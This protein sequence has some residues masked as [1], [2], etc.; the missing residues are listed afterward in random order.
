M[1]STNITEHP[2]PQPK[3]F[4]GRIR[5]AF[6]ATLLPISLLFILLMGGATYVQSRVLIE[7][8]LNT[9]LEANLFSLAQD[10]DQWLTTKVIRLGLASNQNPFQESIVTVV[11]NNDPLSDEFIKSREY[12]LEKLNSITRADRELIFNDFVVTMPDGK[13]IVATNRDW[14]GISLANTDYF[15]TLRNKTG[16]YAV[17]APEPFSGDQVVILTSYPQLDNN[18]DL[19]A[20]TFGLS[21]S[22]PLQ[23]IISGITRLHPDAN[24]YIISSR[25]EFI[26]FPYQGVPTILQPSEEQIK[27]LVPQ[28][29]EYI[30]GVSEIQHKVLSINSFEGS[31]TITDFTWLPTLGIGL[32]IEIPQ[33]T[34]F[35][36][37]NK[38]GPFT[39][40]LTLTT[41][42]LLGTFIMLV[43]QRFVRPITTLTQATEKFAQGNWDQRAVI[44]RDDEIGL[45]SYTF[46]QMAD[47]LAKS[48]RS[49]EIQVLERTGSLEKRTEQLEATA[50]VARETAAIRDL[51]ELL[52][53]STQ[54]ISEHFGY[55][56]V[57]IFLLD[58]P[59]KFAILQAANSEGGKRMLA[60]AHKLG[61][62]QTGVVGHVAATGL[63]RIALD[64]G[65]D[66]FYFDNPDLPQTRSE[67]ALPLKIRNRIIGVLDVQSTEPSAFT[68]TDTEI[69]QVLADQISLAIENARLLEQSQNTLKELQSVYGGQIRKGWRQQ[70]GLQS[71][72][73]YFDRVRVKSASEDQLDISELRIGDQPQVIT[74]NGKQVLAAPIIIRGQKLGIIA[75]RRD[76]EETSWS[77]E[78]VALVQDSIAQIAVALDNARLLDETRRQ[79]DYEQTVGEISNRISRSIDVDSILRTAVRELG[80]LPN[81]KGASIHIGS[82]EEA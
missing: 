5:N 40:I 65:S 63:P 38:L 3:Q 62:G 73:Y 45:L 52:T 6:L 77:Q 51:G 81:V 32:V 13:V 12:I 4:R 16:S 34:A 47:D 17:F 37:L 28:L 66:A 50:Q 46:N 35:G 57:G 27:V 21:S 42:L 25:D 29:S 2:I 18:G 58:D 14:L 15:N 26:G 1:S 79:A 48:Y 8:Q 54:L 67:M 69:L 9:Q 30:F 23:N 56:H 22:L 74:S 11:F 78:D 64:V 53:Y 31:P 7:D 33:E 43:A 19:L 44:N 72:T 59:R 60:R 49:L 76:A 39:V 70:L 24:S 41:G 71:K 55:Y 82:P 61:V 75:L 20:M 80:Q 68:E 36:P 10:I